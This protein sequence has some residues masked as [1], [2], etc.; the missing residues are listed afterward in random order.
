MNEENEI[1]KLRFEKIKAKTIKVDNMKKINKEGV[2]WLDILDDEILITS[3]Y[4]G[5]VSV[6]NVEE[7]INENFKIEEKKNE[8]IEEE[9]EEKMKIEENHKK[10]KEPKKFSN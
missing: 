4:D 7:N 5:C 10:I 9:S 1:V 8:N 3:C 6:W 2:G